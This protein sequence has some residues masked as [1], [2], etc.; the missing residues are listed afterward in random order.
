MCNP[1]SGPAP[2]WAGNAVGAVH[3]RGTGR[4]SAVTFGEMQ[5][6]IILRFRARQNSRR[7]R[8]DLDQLRAVSVAAVD[9]LEQMH[10]LVVRNRGLIFLQL[11]PIRLAAERAQVGRGLVRRFLVERSRRP[12]GRAEGGTRT[13]A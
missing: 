10:E 8:L 7:V 12:A 5:N 11:A 6:E 3:Q 13:R 2:A 1:A 9:S 4:R